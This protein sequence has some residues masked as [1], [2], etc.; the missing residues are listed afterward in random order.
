MA[1]FKSVRSKLIII[2]VCLL[3]G[4]TAYRY[5]FPPVPPI[6]YPT[7]NQ[8]G[9]TEYFLGQRIDLE[10]D[11]STIIEKFDDT[12]TNW[13]LSNQVDAEYILD[14]LCQISIIRPDGRK[15]IRQDEEENPRGYNG[16]SI[17]NSLGHNIV[18][19]DYD[20]N[21]ITGTY[22]VMYEC[23]SQKTSA[24]I[25]ILGLPAPYTNLTKEVHV[26]FNFPDRVNIWHDKSWK[27]GMKISNDL[28]A[29]VKIELPLSYHSDG[30]RGMSPGCPK[31]LT[32]AAW[33]PLVTRLHYPTL[34]ISFPNYC[35]TTYFED[36]PD[37]NTISILPGQ[38]YFSEIE[39]PNDV[40]SLRG[41]K[42]AQIQ[43]PFE[44]R[45]GFI[46]SIYASADKN[47]QIELPV[48]VTTCY[49][50]SGEKESECGSTPQ[51]PSAIKK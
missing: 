25:K 48:N 27:V 17:T 7:I 50:A 16:P 33:I 5:F 32:N 35:D 1:L 29:P 46:F 49:S 39:L 20:D 4:F 37:K 44:M 28:A 13:D 19:S 11:K 42:E 26:T 47:L 18:L 15:I 51:T 24:F 6:L 3:V 2:A 31:D 30:H 10:L 12:G 45:N 21:M 9:H 14:T 23:G 34:A 36:S 41:P 40:A 8:Y 43:G 22:E 38:S